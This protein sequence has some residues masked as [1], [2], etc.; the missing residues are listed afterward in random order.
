MSGTS[1][2]RWARKKFSILT[3]ILFTYLIKDTVCKTKAMPMRAIKEMFG[4]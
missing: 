2:L 4:K 3:L 1:P